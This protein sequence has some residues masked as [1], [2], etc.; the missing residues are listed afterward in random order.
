MMSFSTNAEENSLAD[1]KSKEFA[2]LLEQEASSIKQLICEKLPK[3][4]ELC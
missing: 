3:I 1:A 2:K 4:G